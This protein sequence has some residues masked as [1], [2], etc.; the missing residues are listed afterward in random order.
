MRH[1]YAWLTITLIACGEDTVVVVESDTVWRGDIESYGTVQG[2]G[3][4]EFDISEAKEEI[5]WTFVKQS[6]HG[7]LRVYADDDTWLGLGSQVDGEQTTTAPNG[8]VQ[9]CAR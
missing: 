6:E 8:Q 1:L 2:R 9:G 3:N 7:T 4:A 5:C